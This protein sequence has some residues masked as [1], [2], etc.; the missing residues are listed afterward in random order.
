M[1]PSR[2][3][4]RPWRALACF[5]RRASGRDARARVARAVAIADE[6]VRWLRRARGREV[7]ASEQP[8]EPMR[9]QDADTVPFPYQPDDE[10]GLR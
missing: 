4:S 5:V 3:F 2:S 10:E 9:V 7:A 6:Y 8:T 1:P